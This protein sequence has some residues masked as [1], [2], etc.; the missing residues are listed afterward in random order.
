MF[1]LWLVVTWNNVSWIVYRPGS[2][3]LGPPFIEK[4]RRATN[5]KWRHPEVFVLLAFFVII[6]IYGPSR[7][8]PLPHPQTV[9]E[10]F[11]TEIS[12]KFTVMPFS[13]RWV[14][15]CV[16]VCMCVCVHV[17]CWACWFHMYRACEEE[18]KARMGV[19]E[20][21]NHNLV[22]PFNVLYEKDG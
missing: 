21:L 15:Q 11:F 7:A 13:L 8:T 20:C 12:N 1:N 9:H 19:V 17:L 14:S 6:T 2:R 10:A 4:Q 18:S 5:S 22:E 3:T 16:C